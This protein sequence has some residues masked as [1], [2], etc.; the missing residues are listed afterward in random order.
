MMRHMIAFATLALALSFTVAVDAANTCTSVL[1]NVQYNS[2]A[3]VSGIAN[4]DAGTPKIWSTGTALARTGASVTVNELVA[5]PARER[6]YDTLGESGVL[7]ADANATQVWANRD[8][9]LLFVVRDVLGVFRSDDQA[10]SWTHTLEMSDPDIMMRDVD[11]SDS[12]KFMV[13]A[14][15]RTPTVTALNPGKPTVLAS[16]DGGKTWRQGRGLIVVADWMGVAVSRDGDF[17]I[18]VGSSFAD[19]TWIA[20]SRDHG[21]SWLIKNVQATLPTNTGFG[22][23]DVVMDRTDHSSIY[24]QM[25]LGASDNWLYKS[26]DD[27]KTWAQLPGSS[28]SGQKCERLVCDEKCSHMLG[29]QCNANG[30]KQSYDGGD[31]WRDLPVSGETAALSWKNPNWIM[32]FEG[33]YARLS[34]DGG[35]TFSDYASMIT[36]GSHQDL[37]HCQ[38]PYDP[39]TGVSTLGD[40]SACSVECA[41]AGVSIP[42]ITCTAQGLPFSASTTS[43]LSSATLGCVPPAATPGYDVSGCQKPVSHRHTCHVRCVNNVPNKLVFGRA[44]ARC[45]SSTAVDAF[46]LSGCDVCDIGERYC[47]SLGAGSRCVADCYTGCT[48]QPITQTAT[49]MCVDTVVKCGSH[50]ACDALRKWRGKPNMASIVCANDPCVQT[51]C[52]DPVADFGRTH[53]KGDDAGLFVG[54]DDAVVQFGTNDKGAMQV[55]GRNP[56]GDVDTVDVVEMWTELQE[57]KHEMGCHRLGQTYKRG[58]S[59]E[60]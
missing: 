19:E 27:G 35:D 22:P 47:P 26:V 15:S 40:V 14:Q 52:C 7:K 54:A 53:L 6:M 38:L 5:E 16:Q 13:A 50:F 18:A 10:L 41:Y 37:S 25:E 56:S 42:T 55:T 31:T 36:S 8:D 44:V 48:L 3:G 45:V 21:R 9:S 11:G 34:R 24:V 2:N 43:C 23:G 58:H 51:E 39:A 59:C 57:L 17:M 1:G 49:S 28:W 30:L 32:M 20:T 60:N 12:G 46:S 29:T 4:W 33:G